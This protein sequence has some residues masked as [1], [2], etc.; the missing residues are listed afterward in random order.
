MFQEEDAW[1]RYVTK[2]L[3]KN[4]KAIME[5]VSDQK[6]RKG[7]LNF[8]IHVRHKISEDISGDISLPP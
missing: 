6:K 2:Y 1:T 3:K 7:L 4:E 5:A 8:S